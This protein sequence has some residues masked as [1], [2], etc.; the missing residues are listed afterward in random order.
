MEVTKFWLLMLSGGYLLVAVNKANIIFVNQF[1]STYLKSSITQFH[2]LLELSL[3]Q[4]SPSLF[5]F[6][7][8]IPVLQLQGWGWRRDQ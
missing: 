3:A 6:I 4:L 7:F 2:F 8:P 5:F 1:T